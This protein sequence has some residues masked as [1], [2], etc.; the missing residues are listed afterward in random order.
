MKPAR[1]KAAG[2]PPSARDVLTRMR[3]LADPRVRAAQARFGVDTRRS[4]GLDYPTIKKLARGVPRNHS[5]A[6][7]LWRSGIH[8]ARHMAVLLAEPEKMT[9]AEVDRWARD[10]NS[11]DVVDGTTRYLILYTP[12]AWKKAVQWSRRREEFIKRAAFSLMAY[13]AVHD[14][15]APDASFEKLLPIIS[16][17]ADD[18][19]NFV[20]KAVNWALRQIGKRN[21]RLNHAA[22][23]TA[24]RIRKLDSA[25]ARWIAADALRELLSPAVQRRLRARQRNAS[26]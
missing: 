19:R 17:E 11:W 18:S 4:L 9:E 23:R 5:L 24:E 22:I 25:S 10:F 3:T 1:R 8:E 2:P 16:R 6:R 14:K 26:R 7:Q 20:K 12:Y 21:L 15:A 13:L